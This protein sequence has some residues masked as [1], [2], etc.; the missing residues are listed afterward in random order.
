MDNTCY[1]NKNLMNKK[2]AA[3]HCSWG[4]CNM[5]PRYPDRMKEGI[6]FV[7]FAKSYRL[8]NTMS[9]WERRQNFKRTENAKRWLLA[10]GKKD[11]ND[12]KKIENVL[13]F[14]PFILLSSKDL[15]KNTLIL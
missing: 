8:K 7:T 13:I 5:D 1:E 15:L 3:K 9:D 14:V 6:F 4:L 2:G 12:I 10:C 11:F